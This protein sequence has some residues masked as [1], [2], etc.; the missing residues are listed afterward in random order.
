MRGLKKIRSF[1][2]I[3]LIITMLITSVVTA[4]A[5]NAYYLLTREFISLN[6]RSMERNKFLILSR[7]WQ[8]DFDRAVAI[9]NTLDDRH[10]ILTCAEA[11][12]RYDIGHS[13]IIR[14]AN[15]SVDSFM[16]RSGEPNIIYLNDSLPLVRSIIIP[17]V[18]NGDSVL[19]SGDKLYSSEEIMSAE[20][21][22]HE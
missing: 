3:E 2:I 5:Y 15:G 4:I 16:V 19:L 6:R 11:L 8:N 13:Y 1:T 7:V 21:T 18:V 14:E 22:P 12:I 9:R 17:V 20:I 10:F